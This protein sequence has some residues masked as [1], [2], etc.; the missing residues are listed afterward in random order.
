MY[1]AFSMIQSQANCTRLV[2]KIAV[3]LGSYEML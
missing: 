1:C 2:K 3:V